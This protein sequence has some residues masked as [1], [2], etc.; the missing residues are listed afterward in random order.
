MVQGQANKQVLLS[1]SETSG[2]LAPEAGAVAG[3]SFVARSMGP[4]QE[5]RFEVQITP[6]GQAPLLLRHGI[7]RVK[8][9]LVLDYSREDRCQAGLLCLFSS[10]ERHARTERR[11]VVFVLTP[12]NRHTEKQRANFGNLLPLLADGSQRYI[13]TLKEARLA[14]DGVRFDLK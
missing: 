12:D 13:S 11:D 14:I 7:Y 6:N 1:Y 8:V 3:L 4:V 10:A 9:R 2:H 5:G